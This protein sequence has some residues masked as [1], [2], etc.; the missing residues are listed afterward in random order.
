MSEELKMMLDHL[1]GYQMSPKEQRDQEID[2]AFGNVHFENNRVTRSMVAG[3]LSSST[4]IQKI[5][6]PE[7]TGSGW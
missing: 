5:I 1:R 4:E 3:S 6:P 2:F 7:R